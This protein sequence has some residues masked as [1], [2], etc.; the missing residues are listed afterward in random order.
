[1]SASAAKA[2]FSVFTLRSSPIFR[3]ASSA[4]TGLV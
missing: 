3:S 2:P 1:L 4:L